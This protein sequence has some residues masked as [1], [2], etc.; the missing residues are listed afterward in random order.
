MNIKKPQYKEKTANHNPKQ[1]HNQAKKPQNQDRTQKNSMCSE[2]NTLKM[3]L[4]QNAENEKKESSTAQLVLTKE[5]VTVEQEM[6]VPLN[7]CL[8]M[9]KG[10]NM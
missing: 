1:S 5:T 9:H 2:I 7:Y 6:L 8:H 3:Q 10:A 4:K